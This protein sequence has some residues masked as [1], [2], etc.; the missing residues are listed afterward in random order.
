MLWL[1]GPAGAG[2]SAIAQTIADTCAARNRL[3]TSFFF[4]PTAAHRN[5]V[6]Y[7]FLT[8]AVQIA[9]SVP[10]KSQR[11]DE[12]I[13]TDPYIAERALGSV[14]LLASLLDNRPAHAPRASSAPSHYRWSR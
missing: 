10:E 8:I 9:L 13:N 1:H 7:L 4:A 12:I 2:K 5:E 14:D 11:L 6:K 3:A